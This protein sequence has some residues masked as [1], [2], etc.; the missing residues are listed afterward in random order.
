MHEQSCERQCLFY[1]SSSPFACLANALQYL[2]D[3]L[4][5]SNMKNRQHKLYMAEVSITCLQGF[6]AG[7][8]CLSFARNT[9]A[10]VEGTIFGIIAALV[11]IEEAA[12]GK[13][14][15]RLVDDVLIRPSQ[16]LV[17]DS[18]KE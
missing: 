1:F 13:L 11:K 6:A 4:E 5:V 3:F 8:A 12:V 15:L 2:Y 9:H 16:V 17:S 18:C 14:Y 10:L 7:I